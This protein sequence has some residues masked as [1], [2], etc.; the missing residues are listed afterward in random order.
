MIYFLARRVRTD[1]RWDAGVDLAVGSREAAQGKG[2]RST[3]TSAPQVEKAHPDGWSSIPIVRRT[4][5]ARGAARSGGVDLRFAAAGK[6]MY[7]GFRL[8]RMYRTPLRSEPR[9]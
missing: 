6:T 8:K 7:G 2:A 3:S 1:Q 9:T 5:A 4:T